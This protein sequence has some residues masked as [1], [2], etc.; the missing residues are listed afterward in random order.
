[1][2]VKIDLDKENN[3]SI[4]IIGQIADKQKQLAFVVGGAVRDAILKRTTTDIDIV[5]QGNAIKL[6][7]EFAHEIGGKIT[8][9]E[10]FK[11]ATVVIKDNQSI[12]FITAR[13]ETYA[14]PGSLP[15]VCEGDIYDDLARRDITINALAFAINKSSYGVL[16]DEFGGLKD[17]KDGVVRI[18]HKNSFNDD[19][20]RIFRVIRYEQRLGFKIDRWTSAQIKEAI[21]KSVFKTISIQRYYAELKKIF[22]EEHTKLILQR[23]SQYGVFKFL[24]RGKVINF[25]TLCMVQRGVNREQKIISSDIMVQLFHLGFCEGFVRLNKDVALPLPKPIKSSLS[26]LKDIDALITKL[27]SAKRAQDVY[28]HLGKLPE[29]VQY[30]L[31]VRTQRVGI[32]EKVRDYLQRIRLI[33][34]SITGE[35]LKKLGV[36]SGKKMGIIKKEILLA[37]IDNKIS[38]KQEELRLAKQL[39]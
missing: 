5:I 11:T 16:F 35:D 3:K 17:L 36:T 38:T 24:T 22:E 10:T 6:A 4:A 32:I 1:V 37:K 8:I 9:Y 2:K 12:D 19:P 39:M 13:R 21:S 29:I 26:H 27:G 34:I 7:K 14:K 30:Y 25:H 20:T 28:E 18:L 15:S 23:L 33:E 31:L